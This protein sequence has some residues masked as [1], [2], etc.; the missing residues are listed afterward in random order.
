[1]AKA[2]ELLLQD[3]MLRMQQK[4][5]KGAQASLQ[6]ALK[7]SPGDIRILQ[8]L[9]GTYV[10]QK[11][12]PMALQLIRQHASEHPHSAPLQYFLGQWLL[13]TG[14][15]QQARD[16][17]LAAKNAN[18]RF[19][20]AY[21]ALAQLE[22]AAGNLP[23]AR[24]ILTDVLNT[25]GENP[26]VR[27][28][29]GSIEESANNPTAAV[30]H[31]RKVLETE[32]DNII[33]TNNLACL[34]ADQGDLGAALSLAQQNMEIAGQEPVVEDTLGWI[35]YQKGIYKEAL[36]YFESAFSK[37]G[38][39]R[40]QYHLAMAYSMTGDDRLASQAYL[41]ALKANPNLPEAKLAGQTMSRNGRF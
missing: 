19:L 38:S 32:P 15:A 17:F 7:Q 3:G 6:Q 34:L 5:Y 28:A 24:Q 20:D 13:R 29:L 31:Y 9:A 36:K 37:A 41:S 18:P 14:N 4:D 21:L 12:Q 30:A 23:G 33:A 1:V 10:A 16:A 11:Q 35:L 39:P 25:Q 40:I 26:K 8:A 22:V 27:L 2:A